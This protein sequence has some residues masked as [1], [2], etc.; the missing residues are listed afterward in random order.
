MDVD[1]T[2]SI[3]SLGIASHGALPITMDEYGEIRVPQARGRRQ[4]IA[5]PAKNGN[6]GVCLV[7]CATPVSSLHSR[8]DATKCSLASKVLPYSPTR[9]GG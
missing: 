6:P 1:P 4:R 3:R 8:N 5:G 7:G 9:E 2:K